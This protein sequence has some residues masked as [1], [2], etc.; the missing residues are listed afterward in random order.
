MI[1]PTTRGRSS[2]IRLC[3]CCNKSVFLSHDHLLS[4]SLERLL[5]NPT[6]ATV[7][8]GGKPLKLLEEK[9]IC[10]GGVFKEHLTASSEKV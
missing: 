1:Q 5:S 7:A 3:G 6:L 4:P 9:L 10:S 2:R 8:M